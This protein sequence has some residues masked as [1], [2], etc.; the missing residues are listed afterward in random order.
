MDSELDGQ[1]TYSIDGVSPPEFT[2]NPTTGQLFL[3]APLDFDMPPN[4][5]TVVIRAT[6]GAGASDPVTSTVALRII[7][8]D[9]ND[10]APR[11]PSAVINLT[12]SENV[13]KGSQVGIIQATD[14][15]SGR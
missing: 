6:D 10:N 2:I 1:I 5:Y 14:A 7:V 8:S 15:G 3:S 11:F 13:T 9:V 4:T 12:V